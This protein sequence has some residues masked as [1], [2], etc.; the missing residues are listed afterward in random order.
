MAWFGAK[1]IAG[2]L[3]GVLD[4]MRKVE[5]GDFSVRIEEDRKDEI[6]DL[7]HGFNHMVYKVDDLM[8][9][10][11]DTRQKLVQAEF[12]ALQD[13][14]KPHF[15]YNTLDSINWMARM[16]RTDKVSEMIDS[17]TGFLRI[18]LSRGKDFISLAEEIRHV[19]SYISIQKYDMTGYLII[20]LM[21]VKT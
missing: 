18:G 5:D 13:Q 8:A 9:R 12:N 21:S 3:G 6:G 11:R 10:E 2:P 19:E 4:G 14:I 15:L 16:N 7:I 1:N 20:R 17:L